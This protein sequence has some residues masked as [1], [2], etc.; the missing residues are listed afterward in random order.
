[1]YSPTCVPP[2]VLIRRHLHHPISLP[3]LSLLLYVS[4]AS[5]MF[6]FPLYRVS[7][8]AALP[9]CSPTPSQPPVPNE[10]CN[11]LSWATCSGRLGICVSIGGGGAV[12]TPVRQQPAIISGRRCSGF[13][14]QRN[15]QPCVFR[16]WDA[17]FF[18][19][20]HRVYSESDYLLSL[21]SLNAAVAPGRQPQP[22][23][24]CPST[25]SYDAPT[26]VCII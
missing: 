15:L 23:Q 19:W 21:C 22:D 10:Q 1:M 5:L 9:Y 6:L 25:K 18:S 11:Q 12:A 3:P 16:F 14:I 8:A 24:L 17:A 7:A 2:A 13:G 4:A 26:Y 20:G